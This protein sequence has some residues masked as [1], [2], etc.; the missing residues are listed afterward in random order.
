MLTHIS[1]IHADVHCYPGNESVPLLSG[2]INRVT[3]EGENVTFNCSFGDDYSPAG[4]HMS[5]RLT[6]ENG[7]YTMIADN[8]NYTDFCLRTYQDCPPDNNSCCRFISELNIHTNLSMN[9][10]AV[11]CNATI[12]EHTTSS[13]CHLSEMM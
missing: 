11:S 12:N 6:H 10:V 9:N 2:C 13:I 8:M 7:S 4:Y 1:G 3:I 5:W